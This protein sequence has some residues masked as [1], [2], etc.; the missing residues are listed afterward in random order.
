[1]WIAKALELFLAQLV[2]GCAKEADEKGYSK[3]TPFILKQTINKNEK[4]DFLKDV[5]EKVPDEEEEEAPPKKRRRSQSGTKK[6]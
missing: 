1:M 5:V 3:L 4:F 2:D 6:A